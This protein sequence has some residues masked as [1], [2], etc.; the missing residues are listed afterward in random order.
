MM[1]FKVSIPLASVG[2]AA[3]LFFAL[4]AFATAA[5]PATAA[6]PLFPPHFKTP[7]D[8]AFCCAPVVLKKVT[9]T[10]RDHMTE[11]VGDDLKHF[12]PES[13]DEKLKPLIDAAAERTMAAVGFASGAAK[14]CGLDPDKDT[15]RPIMALLSKRDVHGKSRAYATA[16]HGITLGLTMNQITCTPKV[17]S[18]LLK[19]IQDFRQTLSGF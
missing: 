11:M 9:Q 6:E 19:E 16:I 10:A 2:F 14:S 7:W 5:R 17:R 12:A 8:D 13:A 1:L 3:V 18:R 4:F 15:Y